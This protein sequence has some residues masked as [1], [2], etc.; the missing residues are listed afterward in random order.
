[1]PRRGTGRINRAST[2]TREVC[3]EWRP[4]SRAPAGPARIPGSCSVPE[5]TLSARL[6]RGGPGRPLRHP[7]FPGLRRLLPGSLEET[8]SVLGPSY[9]WLVDVLEITDIRHPSRPALQSRLSRLQHPSHD[10][11][12]RSTLCRTP[13]PIRPRGPIL[14]GRILGLRDR[15]GRPACTSTHNVMRTQ[16]Q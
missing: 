5:T 12:L 4:T 6:V 9:T 10:W 11:S 15:S 13:G 2:T 8:A 16:C 7:T 3:C 14:P 1:M